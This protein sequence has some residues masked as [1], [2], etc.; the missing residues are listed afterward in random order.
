MVLSVMICGDRKR[1]KVEIQVGIAVQAREAEIL[2]FIR[3]MA[4]R[5]CMAAIFSIAVRSLLIDLFKWI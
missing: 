4:A 3:K 2:T 1:L 5:P